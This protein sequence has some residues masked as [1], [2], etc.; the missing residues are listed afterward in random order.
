MIAIKLQRIWAVTLR[1]LHQSLRD[2]FMIADFIYWPLIDIVIW[3]MMSVWLER[4]GN[5]VPNIVIIIVSGLVLWQIVYQANMDI[6]NNLIE[7]VW[8]QN[9]VN[10]FS[11]P[12]TVGEWISAVMLLGTIRMIFVMIFGTV[13]AWLLYAFN[14]F[15]MGWA[16]I[17]F[18]LSLLLTGW[19]LGFCTA[20]FILYG[21]M[22][23]HWATWA[24]GAFMSPFIGIYYPADT[25]P[26]FCQIISYALPP[27]YVFEGMR[28]IIFNGVI[29]YNYLFISLILNAFY[30]TLAI[31]FFKR[32]F[33]K[34]RIMGLNRTE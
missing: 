1:Y 20:A 16:L 29:P 23:V 9:L 10:M 21:G 12:L 25:L 14:V 4:S 18:T 30:L 24:M 19:A 5:Q 15:A 2:L 27:T 6:T 34:S 28:K 26:W 7:E 31:Y 17:P 3:G 33:E 13:V 11:S 22:R 32:M 8:S